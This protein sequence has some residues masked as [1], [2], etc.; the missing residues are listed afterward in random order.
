ME[1]NLPDYEYPEYSLRRRYSE[2]VWL[3]K[4]LKSQLDAKGKRLSLPD[5]PGNTIS[6]FFG[7]G[8]YEA[9]FIESRRQGLESFLQSIVRHP[10]ARF[11]KGLHSFLQDPDFEC[12]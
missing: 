1:T 8:R 4:H 5:L 12:K 9:D 3:R 11:E 10:W 7:P 6:S 2:F